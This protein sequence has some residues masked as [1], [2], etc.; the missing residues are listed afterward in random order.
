MADHPEPVRLFLD[1]TNVAC[2]FRI[3]GPAG[4]VV[5]LPMADLAVTCVTAS[6][7][8]HGVCITVRLAGHDVVAPPVRQPGRF[9]FP[10]PR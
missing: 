5:E 9:Q 6:R 4:S 1:G 10:W 2:R 3:E 8:E 7:D